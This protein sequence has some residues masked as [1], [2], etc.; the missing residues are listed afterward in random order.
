MN[1]LCISCKHENTC[2]L[3]SAKESI[4]HCSEYIDNIIFTDLARS[5]NQFQSHKYFT[6]SF[7]LCTN[8][9]FKNNCTYNEQ[10]KVIFS[11]EHYQ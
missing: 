8:C 7:G 5:T 3:T 4:Y 1:T 9:D 10:G 11:C 6:A 2:S